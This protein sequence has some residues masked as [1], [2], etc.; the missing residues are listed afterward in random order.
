MN[1]H[2]FVFRINTGYTEEAVIM[3]ATRVTAEEI[4]V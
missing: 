4:N 2:A 1:R 3:E